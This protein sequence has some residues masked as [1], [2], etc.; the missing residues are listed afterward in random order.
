[1]V[2]Y[3]AVNCGQE[4]QYYKSTDEQWR[5]AKLYGETLENYCVSSFGGIT[6]NGE[7]QNRFLNK[8]GEICVLIDNKEILLYTIVASTFLPEPNDGYMDKE[9][10]QHKAIHHKDNNSYNFLPDNMQF[11]TK[12]EHD[13]APHLYRSNFNEWESLI[14]KIIKAE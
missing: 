10:N 9:K 2:L 13:N 3:Y 4:C 14:S 1:M 11:M 8:K 6:K 5:C 12:A 7:N